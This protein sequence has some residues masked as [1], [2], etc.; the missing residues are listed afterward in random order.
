MIILSV[1]KEE[2]FTLI[3]LIVAI[4][5]LSVAVVGIFGAF[6]IMVVLTYDAADR[7]TAAYLAQEGVEIIRNI[8]DSNWLRME[9]ESAFSWDESLS[10]CESAGC[11]VDFF[12]TGDDPYVVMPWYNSDL[13]YLN[14]DSNGFYSYD[15]GGRTK[16]KRKITIETDTGAIPEYVMK[17]SVQV[18]WDK[19]STMFGP[20]ASADTC[21]SSNCMTAQ[22]L[23]YNWYNYIPPTEE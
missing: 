10:F 16:F 18:S 7:L 1:K 13:D 3:E 14:I 9:Q 22:L 2:G 21:G 5:I 20:A 15:I 12:T 11:N 23:L 17:I 19:K 8:R 4:F 6:S